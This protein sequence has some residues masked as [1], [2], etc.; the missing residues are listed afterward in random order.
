MDRRTET[1]MTNFNTSNG[2]CLLAQAERNA[3]SLLEQTDYN[4]NCVLEQTDQGDLPGTSA[5]RK[6]I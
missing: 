3:N 6:K 4:G 2:N 5:F 1:K